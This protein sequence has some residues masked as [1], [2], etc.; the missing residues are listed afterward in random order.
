MGRPSGARAGKHTVFDFKY[1]GPGFGQGGTGILSVDGKEIASRT[2]PH[3]IPFV[4]T[5][6]E[7][8]DVGADTRTGVDRQGLPAAIMDLRVVALMWRA[9][10]PRLGFGPLAEVER[11]LPLSALPPERWGNRPAQLVDS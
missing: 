2:I 9:G 3:A 5:I 10:R 8:F 11:A 1:D 6:Y 4:E 7:T